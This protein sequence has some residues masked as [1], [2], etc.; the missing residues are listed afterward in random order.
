MALKILFL[1]HRIPWPLKDGG[2]IAIYNNLNGFYHQGCQV[3]LL[4][5]NPHKD[6]IS[7]KDIPAEMKERFGLQ[8]V[9]IDTGIRPAAAFANLFSGNSYNITRFFSADFALL[10]Q[11]EL[12]AEKYDLVHFEGLFVGQYVELVKRTSTAKTV[13]REH[14]IEFSIWGKLAAGEKNI[15]KKKY[16]EL[17]ARRLRNYELH[18]W[19]AFDA[20]TTITTQDATVLQHLVPGARVFMAGTGF[21]LPGGPATTATLP[22]TLFHLGSMDWLPNIEG[23]D[24]F[25]QEVWPLLH[26]QFPRW[27]LHLAGK[28]MPDRFLVS[29]QEGIN[30][31][32]EVADAQQFMAD[33][34]VMVVPLLSG[35]GIRIKM[36]EAMAL[37]KVVISTGMGAQGIEGQPG[38]HFFIADTATEFAGILQLLEDT[39][40]L[41]QKTGENARHLM[42]EKYE[43]GAVT[44]RLLLF[45]QSL[46]N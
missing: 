45:Y 10:L 14:N 18:L 13:L 46:L 27:Q 44:Q 4:C 40:G 22:A 6:G 3:K 33:K 1:S 25:L 39:P 24:W 12:A 29:R 43:N 35:S 2:A 28:K 42:A 37:G 31:A 5:L 26:E 38:I 15:L 11:K 23:V 7:A 20:I 17:L 41:L 36:L 21:E 19:E 30:V 34:Q 9:D 8:Y 32:G 16:L